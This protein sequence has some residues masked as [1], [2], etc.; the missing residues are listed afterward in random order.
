MPTI[1]IIIATFNAEK[2]LK[3]ALN[4]VINQTFQDWECIIIDG[5]S[6]DATIQIVK[7]YISKDS[8]FKYISEIDKGIFDAFNKG[9]K[10]AQGKWI[11]YLGADDTLNKFAFEKIH[12]NKIVDSDVLYG[13][14]E[15]IFSNG[16][17]AIKKPQ[18]PS[19]LRYRM[20]AC[21]QSILVKR[22]VIEN[23]NGFNIAYAT[24]A[25]FD[26]MQRIYLQKGK[27]T[28]TNICIATFSYTGISSKYSFK[29][30]HDH[31]IICKNNKSNCCPLFFHLKHEARLYL[32]YLHKRI[33]KRI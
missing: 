3:S 19:T 24:C 20:F 30:H 4:S 22:S 12:I 5:A 7:E 33:L 15:I 21:H 23:V 26:M 29:A 28:Y 17:K 16:K 1:S 8:R 31:Y 2:T 14:I 27:F 18:K 32:G 9:W 10:I 13:N 6:K 25:D 11:Y